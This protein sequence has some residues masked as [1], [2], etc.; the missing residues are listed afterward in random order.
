M[1]LLRTC[2]AILILC[3]PAGIAS[4]FAEGEARGEARLH[5]VQGSVTI[6]TDAQ[7]DRLQRQSITT[8]PLDVSGPAP[9]NEP[10]ARERHR[11]RRDRRID[12]GGPGRGGACDDC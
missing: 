9:S 3:F 7:L 5:L 8:P 6:P 4:P 12:H 2:A 10:K 11:D 1:T